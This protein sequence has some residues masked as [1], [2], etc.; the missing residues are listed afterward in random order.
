MWVR[1]QQDAAMAPRCVSAGRRYSARYF[2]E[3]A[4]EVSM[5]DA[6]GGDSSSGF[7]L[8][9]HPIRAYDALLVKIQPPSAPSPNLAPVGCSIVLVID[10]STS[11]DL[12]AVV[13][14]AERETEAFR[15]T[16][17]D[18]IRHSA[19][20]M[21]KN[22]T[23]RDSLGIVLFHEEAEEKL[24]LTPMDS[25]NKAI[26]EY[27]LRNMRTKVGKNIWDGLQAG[28]DLFE[29]AETEG[30]VPS[31]MLLSDGNAT[32]INPENGFA[33]ELRERLP[34]KPSINTFGFGPNVDAGL[35]AS[36]ASIGDGNYTYISDVGMVCTAFAHAVANI[37]ATYAT[38]AILR[39]AFTKYLKISDGLRQRRLAFDDN[40]LTIFLGNIQY[41]QSRDIVLKVRFTQHKAPP[42]Q[43]HSVDALVNLTPVLE[44][45]GQPT[46]EHKREFLTAP[47]GLTANEVAYHVS[48]GYVC[49]FLGDLLESQASGDIKVPWKD[50]AT[51]KKRL[52]KLLSEIPACKYG[53]NLNRDLMRELQGEHPAGQVHIA[54][55]SDSHYRR[56]GRRYLPSLLS[57][58]ARQICHSNRDPGPLH[59][60][61]SS[62]LFISC[63]DRFEST[64]NALPPPRVV[65]RVTYSGARP[66]VQDGA[67]A[68]NNAAS[69][70]H[71]VTEQEHEAGVTS[72]ARNLNQTRDHTTTTSR[73]HA[74]VPSNMERIA[75]GQ[76]GEQR[77][78]QVTMASFSGNSVCFAH[79]A[80]VLLDSGTFIEIQ[81]IASGTSVRTLAGPRRVS[82]RGIPYPLTAQRGTFR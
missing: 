36:V 80:P 72:P 78:N 23:D 58:H 21:V 4:M 64:F 51:R 19:L 60:G 69:H 30:Q 33:N 28:L 59:Y 45:R 35:M 81:H 14:R 6:Q 13:P 70:M 79:G 16:T 3:L 15:L 34:L 63:R 46:S 18:L 74:R 8:S 26:A 54:V 1:D 76:R 41:G 25:K 42:N 20:T 39:V 49:S 62:P 9:L 77:D 67:R 27:I 55:N 40:L 44:G 73:G 57:A 7:K 24:A 50:L 38:G 2:T 48:R 65:E 52:N 12:L 47:C 22:M 11:M 56:W 71:R 29:T 66:T 37:Q 32:D 43:V 5:K 68:H 31:I 61:V 82:Q 17:L 10:I 53:D 75:E